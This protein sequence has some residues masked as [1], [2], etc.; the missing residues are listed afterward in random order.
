M[1]GIR[2]VAH[3]E[4]LL[5]PAVT[6]RLIEA[7]V[8]ERPPLRPPSELQELTARELE[9]FEELARGRSNAEIAARLVVSTTTVK[10]HVARVLSK[11]GLR[12]RV[13]AVVYAYESGVVSPGDQGEG[14]GSERARSGGT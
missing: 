4:S 3:G 2:L 6:R 13:Q 14:T 5:A 7:F 12:D 11:L 10:T 1:A 9:I 8:R